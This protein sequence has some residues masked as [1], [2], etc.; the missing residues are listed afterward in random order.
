M[1]KLG[2]GLSVLVLSTFATANS[3]MS[4]YEGRYAKD[5]SKKHAHKLSYVISEANLVR[6]I[7]AKEKHADWVETHSDLTSLEGY[8]SLASKTYGDFKVDFY[9]KENLNWAKVRYLGNDRQE[10][11]AKH[12]FMQCI[13]PDLISK[14]SF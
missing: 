4:E 14:S 12:L 6:L 10:K 9:Q 7:D 13:N 11:Q 2:I 5:C 3:G 8:Q 1:K